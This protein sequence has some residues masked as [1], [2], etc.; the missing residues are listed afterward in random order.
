MRL[1]KEKGLFCQSLRLCETNLALNPA[2]EAPYNP[3]HG[4]P[5]ESLLLRR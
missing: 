5:G 4:L 3:D 1:G 2:F